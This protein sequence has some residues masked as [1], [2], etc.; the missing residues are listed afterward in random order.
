MQSPDKKQEQHEK[1]L[2]I[3][4]KNVMKSSNQHTQVGFAHHHLNLGPSFTFR[5]PKVSFSAELMHKV[6]SRITMGT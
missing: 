3:F 1:L 4:D 5:F 6:L 2:N